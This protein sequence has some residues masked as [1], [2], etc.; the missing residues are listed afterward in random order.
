MSKIVK[1]CGLARRDCRTGS[2]L[3]QK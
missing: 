2:Y 3:L 1:G